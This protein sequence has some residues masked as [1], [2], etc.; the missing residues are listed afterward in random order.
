MKTVYM[1]EPDLADL[2]VRLEDEEKFDLQLLIQIQKEQQRT[3]LSSSAM[4]HD[5]KRKQSEAVDRIEKTIS[6]IKYYNQYFL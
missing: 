4:L 6:I 2:I 5:L 3:S 1:F